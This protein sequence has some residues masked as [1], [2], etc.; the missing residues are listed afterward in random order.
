M[1]DTPHIMKFPTKNFF[2][3]TDELYYNIPLIA[4]YKKGCIIE[5]QK[6]IV[7]AHKI[8]ILI[9]YPFLSDYTY[10]LESENG[11]TKDYIVEQII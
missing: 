2:E 8:K 1:D 3:N 5:G 4:Y 11:F 7:K 10:T 6:I 9:G